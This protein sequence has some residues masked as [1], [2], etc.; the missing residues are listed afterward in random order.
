MPSAFQPELRTASPAGVGLGVEAAVERIVVLGLAGGA[1]GEARHRGLRPVVG[2]AAGDGEARAA[3][4]AVEKGI[5]EAAV[6]G[7]EKLAEA[8]RTGGGVGGDAVC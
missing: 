3:V 4:G 8:I 1:H 7:V 6:A 5:T 2:D